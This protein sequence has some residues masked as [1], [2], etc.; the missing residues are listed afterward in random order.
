MMDYENILSRKVQDLQFS[1]IRKFFDIAASYDDVISLSVGEPDF[2]TPWAIRKEAIRVLEKGRTNYTAN[3]GLADLRIAIN[4]YINDRLHVSY[5]PLHE[6]L[7][8]Q[9]VIDIET[10]RQLRPLARDTC[11][12]RRLGS[13]RPCYKSAH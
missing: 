11:N 7:D 13:D 1:G 9:S 2:K 3:A 4:D 6:I 10:A 5:D 12:G 8:V